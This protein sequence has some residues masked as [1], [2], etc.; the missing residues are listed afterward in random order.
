MQSV[1]IITVAVTPE[2][3]RQTRMLAAEYDTTVSAMVAYLLQTMPRALKAA[4][5]PVG[6][7]KSASSARLAQSVSPTT[8]SSATPSEEEI[9]IPG[10]TA[11]NPNLNPSLSKTCVGKPE[12]ITAPVPQY[13]ATNQHI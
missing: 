4:R 12:E 8:A 6:D 13:A 11:V 5:F 1:K 9:A 7:P 2:L 10:C 3:Y